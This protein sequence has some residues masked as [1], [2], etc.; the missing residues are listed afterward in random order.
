MTSIIL[1][2]QPVITVILSIILLGE[3]PS[4][5]QFLG[6]GLVIGGIAAA[7][8]PMARIRDGLVGA[9]GGRALGA[10]EG[11][12]GSDPY[13]WSLG[14]PAGGRHR[15]GTCV[16]L[17]CASLI[18]A[19]RPPPPRPTTVSRRRA[20]SSSAVPFEPARCLSA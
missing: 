15:G 2:S 13:E 10:D 16:F 5:S 11:R 12:P 1:L 18:D 3:A 20:R 9:R 19:D 6:V 17:D 14:P 4:A 8:V 7:T